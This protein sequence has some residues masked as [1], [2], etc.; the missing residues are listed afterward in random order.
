M[1]SPKSLYTLTGGYGTNTSNWKK[2]RPDAFV[3][4]HT[5]N[6]T[7]V[8]ENVYTKDRNGNDSTWTT[9]TD[10]S[11]LSSF[12]PEGMW[13]NGNYDG[14]TAY[15]HR[16]DNNSD[17][18]SVV[19]CGWPYGQAYQDI[20]GAT[21]APVTQFAGIQF[22]WNTADSHWSD[23][24]IR[25]NGK[26]SVGLICYDWDAGKT[27]VQRTDQLFYS[28]RSPITDGSNSAVSNN[29]C[30][31]ILNSSD[32][33]WV[34]QNRIYLV[35]F[36]IQFFQKNE[37]G[38]S[39]YRYFNMWDLQILYSSQGAGKGEGEYPY[40]MVMPGKQANGIGYHGEPAD[41]STRRSVKIYHA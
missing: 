32:V 30:A 38:S 25:I 1:A 31:F 17:R 12:N 41:N 27:Y 29:G 14:S 10:P 9:D 22:K 23:S 39:R 5:N 36:Y 16:T 34:R 37:G 6:T 19:M 8:T 18:Y 7:Y 28:G 13:F 3:P 11:D 40:K 33:T 26:D 15:R 21:S 24:A 20:E 4:F 2:T 35:G